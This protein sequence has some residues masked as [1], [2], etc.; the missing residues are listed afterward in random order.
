MSFT[1]AVADKGQVYEGTTPATYV[2]V[3]HKWQIQSVRPSVCESY[4]WNT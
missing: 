2:S 4:D 3:R 1:G